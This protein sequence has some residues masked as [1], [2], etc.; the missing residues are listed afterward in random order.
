MF[1]PPVQPSY[2]TSPSPSGEDLRAQ[3]TLL[4]ADVERLLMVS[5]ALWRILQEKHGLK[6]GELMRRVEDIDLRDGRLDGRVAPTEPLACPKCGRT[7]FKRR[8][9]CV[10]CG[11]GVEVDPFQR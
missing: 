9:A 10:Y 6:D 3:I 11:Q 8:P 4:R 5:E 2:P 1:H 7:L